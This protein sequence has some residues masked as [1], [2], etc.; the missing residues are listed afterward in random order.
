MFDILYSIDYK[1][2]YDEVYGIDI[3]SQVLTDLKQNPSKDSLVN[4]L[5]SY[6][7]SEL[8][9]HKNIILLVLDNLEVNQIS[10]L[11]RELNI[12]PQNYQYDTALKIAVL[13]WNRTSGLPEKLNKILSYSIPEEYLPFGVEK[14]NLPKVEKV[15]ALKKQKLAGKKRLLKRKNK[16]IVN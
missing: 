12:I 6:F 1:K 5:L 10:E 13:G 3:A 15:F 2:L 4:F 16:K 14:V 8:L 9:N 11:C 7:G